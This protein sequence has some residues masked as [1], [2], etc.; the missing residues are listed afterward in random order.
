MHVV[1]TCTCHFKDALQYNIQNLIGVLDMVKSRQKKW[2]IR[3]EEISL[4]GTTRKIFVGE[5]E[6]K[7][8][9]GRPKLK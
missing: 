8:P 2:K 1:H 3:V 5:M 4:E 6:G 7:R 9:R